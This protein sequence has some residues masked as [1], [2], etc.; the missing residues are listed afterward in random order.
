MYDVTKMQSLVEEMV[1]LGPR[2]TGNKAHAEFIGIIKR[3]LKE[4]GVPCF[5]DKLT[6]KKRWEPKRWKLVIDD[7]DEKFEIKDVSYYPYS[8]VTD[9]EGVSGKLFDAGKNIGNYMGSANKIA[10]IAMSVFEADAGLVFKKRSVY[11]QDY[12][13]PKKMAS[14]VVSSFVFAPML[15][16]A[17]RMGAKGVIC[18]MHGCS[19]D[20]AAHQYLPFITFYQDCPALWVNDIDGARILEAEKKGGSA[21]LVLEADI[22]EKS[23]TQSLYVVLQGK[24]DNETILI[25]THTDGTNAFEEN[26]AI[27][28]LSLIEHFS[29]IPEEKR[30]RTLIFS[31]ITGHFQLPQFGSPLNQATNRFLKKHREFWDGKGC[32]RKAVAGVSIEHLGCTEWRDSKDRKEYM[33]VSDIDPELVFVA[34][35]KLNKLYLDCLKE[36]KNVKTM[37][38]KPKNFVYFGE[39]QPLYLVG[40]PTISLCPGPDYL[41]TNSP[42]GY[43][44]KM[45]YE[46][47]TEQVETFKKVIERLDTMPKKEIGRCEPFAFGVKL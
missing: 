22:V 23:P 25:N 26:G 11:P 16:R 45:N 13:P 39:G 38:L 40:I 1:S 20:N 32:H 44:E 15:K 41:C 29:R 30:E 10:V 4:M 14:P 27:G 19:P 8:G 9:A 6:L 43:L 28:L 35:S 34:N 33:K 12:C 24:N 36:R 42:T 17:K 5:Q 7:G 47:M 21:E 46:L 37:T 2:L 18:I 31:F 3:E